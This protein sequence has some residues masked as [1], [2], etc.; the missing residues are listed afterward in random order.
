MNTTHTDTAAVDLVAPALDHRTAMRL[1]AT[2]YRRMADHLA[3]L[4]PGD[5]TRPTD[6]PAWDVR[7]MGCHMVGMAAM[8]TGPREQRRQLRLAA[9]EVAA[10]GITPLDALTGLQVSERGT[11]T[12]D[13]VVAG[14]RKVGP[15]AAR[16]R[17]LTPGFVRRRRLPAPQTVGGRVEHWSIGFLVDVILTRDP[18]MHRM[19]I[20]HATG[21]DPVLTADH[22][23]VIVG[24]VVAE[25]ARRHGSPYRLTLTGPAGGTWS[26]GAGGD[27]VEMDAVEFC[28][29]VSGRRSGEGLLGVEVPF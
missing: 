21:H 17:R 4:E 14:A 10:Q 22:D 13:E 26:S 23:G 9:A 18:W 29:T 19:D 8:A 6:C 7:Q 5:W 20:A 28:R 27:Q 3:A 16:G 2:E 24:D 11:W 15:K 25:W 1:A 12:P